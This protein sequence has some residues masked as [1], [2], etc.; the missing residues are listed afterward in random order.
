MERSQKLLS[1]EAILNIAALCK[2][3]MAVYTGPEI[4]IQFANDAM[5]G[6]WGKDRSVIGKPLIEAVPE[7]RG[8]PFINL[9]QNVWETGDTYTA[10]DVAA[11]LNVDG[12]LK[13]YYF[14]FEYRALLDNEQQ[15]Y[16]ILHTATEVTDRMKAWEMV[17][18][19]EALQRTDHQ[20]LRDQEERLRLAIAS[21]DLGTWHINAE[22][23][24]FQ[25]S[26]RLKAL[27]GYYPDDPMT[28]EAAVA[29][30]ADTHRERVVSAVESAINTGS[31]YDQEYPVVGFHDHRLRWVKATGKLYRSANGTHP[32]H[33]SGTVADI[34]D[35][36]MEEQ[37][38]NDFFGIVSHELRSPLTSISGY[39]QV[40][41]VKAKKIS[42]LSIL[43][44]V[45]KGKRQVS[46]MSNIISGFLDVARLGE[47]KI[48]LNKK[49]F[50]MADLVKAAEAESLATITS[51][52]VIFH[53]VEYTPVNADWDKVEQVV[54][55]FVN[56]AVKYSPGNT[57]IHVACMTRNGEAHVSVADEG[58]GIP[59]KDQPHIFERFYRVAGDH[60][61]TVKGFGIGLY[62]SKEIIEAHGGRIGVESVEERG[63]T[64]WF[65]LPVIL[66]N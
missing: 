28:Y 40:L 55:N 38:K 27:F 48:H 32:A 43:D 59:A 42:D 10:K 4:C 53:P 31:H 47:S 63:S 49:R 12:N 6:F 51:H 11:D 52:Q 22:T 50:D 54:V 23:R 39:L 45:S 8:Q 56:N 16:A 14:D 44:I 15:I 26:E 5:I 21:A 25:T 13:V 61:K 30:I 33:F 34:T 60:T 20:H 7:L 57:T 36:K 29:Q 66:D 17:R 35:R 37:R 1:S 46:R 2:D 62:I 41:E 18:E 19:K 9:L 24:E 3:A 64:F 58:M 65:D